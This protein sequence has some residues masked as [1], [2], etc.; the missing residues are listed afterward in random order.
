MLI[1]RSLCLSVISLLVL[2]LAGTAAAQTRT[3]P[4]NGTW[5][6][7]RGPL[8]DIPINGAPV[9]CPLLAAGKHSPAAAPGCV[10]ILFPGFGA[11][12]S[13]GGVPA[14]MS[15]MVTAMGSS[16]ATL[17]VPPNVFGQALGKQVVAVA[18]VPTVVQLATTFTFMAPRTARLVSP[19]A[20]TR[21]FKKSA[22]LSQTGRLAKSFTWCPGITATGGGGPGCLNAAAGAYN[23][24]VRYKANPNGFGGTMTLLLAGTGTVSV[25]AG[26]SGGMPLLLHQ[27]LAGGG[28]Q[29][30][31]RGYAN[32]DT[33]ILGGGAIHVG[34][35][36]APPCTMSLPPVPAGCGLITTS[37]PTMGSGAPDSNLNYGFP[38][39]TGAVTAQNTGTNQGMAATTT[40]TAMGLDARTGLG[41]GNLTLVAGGASHRFGLATMNPQDFSSLDVVQLRMGSTKTPS[42]SP[43]GLAAGAVLMLLAVG[44]A[45]RPR[46]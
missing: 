6:Q 21:V 5:W 20:N 37:G 12:P 22:W 1:R 3:F 7:N 19:P 2:A 15:A 17:T 32:T 27:P 40:L 33:D 45:L 29:A 16:P 28:S 35:M 38:W 25:V 23:G 10:G 18:V 11:V 30:Q 9:P 8:V 36:T 34:F 39:T 42:S 13:G 4:M 31:G 14:T 44:F 46:A 43:A 41:S 26:T 24:L